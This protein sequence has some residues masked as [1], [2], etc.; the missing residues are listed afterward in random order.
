[1]R[2]HGAEEGTC[3]RDVDRRG[4][5]PDRGRSQP[6]ARR[7]S[8]INPHARLRLQGRDLRETARR[9]A[10]SMPTARAAQAQAQAPRASS[11]PSIR[12]GSE[13]LRWANPAARCTSPPFGVPDLDS[14]AV[15]QPARHAARRGRSAGRVS[16]RSHR[17]DREPAPARDRWASCAPRSTRAPPGRRDGASTRH[18]FD[19]LYQSMVRRG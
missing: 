19:T 17:A 18:V 3:R 10:W 6:G 13:R 14:G 11:R 8:G 5:T 16:G 15:H 2:T 9:A 1:M 4:A 7:R 12:E